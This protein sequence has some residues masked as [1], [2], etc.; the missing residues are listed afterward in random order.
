MAENRRRAEIETDFLM[1]IERLVSGRPTHPAL[2]KRKEE[3]GRLAI[4]ISNVALE[5][6][7]SR[8]LIA[9]RD[10]TYPTVKHRLMELAKPH[11]SRGTATT[12]IDLRAELSETRKQLKMALAEAAGHFHARVNA[13]RDAARWRQA[14]ERLSSKRGDE[15]NIVLLKS[16]PAQ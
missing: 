3:T 7:R 8:T 13:E 10:T 9:T 4:N 1:A 15:S 6:G 16:P 11:A 14:Y 5:A 2:K 12:I